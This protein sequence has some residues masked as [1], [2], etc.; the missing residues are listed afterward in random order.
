MREALKSKESQ[1]FILFQSRHDD[2]DSETLPVL[3][4]L[5]RVGLKATQVELSCVRLRSKFIF[6]EYY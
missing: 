4:V 6:F 5:R 3:L 2:T 1:T